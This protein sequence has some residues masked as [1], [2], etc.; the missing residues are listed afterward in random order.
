MREIKY[1]RYFWLSVKVEWRIGEQ[2]EG[3]AG[4]GGGN[5]GN[6][7]GMRGM[8]VEIRGMRVGSIS[9]LLISLLSN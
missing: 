6:R 2:N 4:N 7:V 9:F 5:K 3:N 8:W 1:N